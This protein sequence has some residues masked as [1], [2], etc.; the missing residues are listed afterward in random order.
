M[1]QLNASTGEFTIGSPLT[2]NEVFTKTGH[3]VISLNLVNNS[4]YLEF[5][6]L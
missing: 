2:L 3:P 1:K 4:K 6:F 5:V